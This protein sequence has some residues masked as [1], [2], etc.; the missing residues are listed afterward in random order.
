M[1]SAQ[2]LV[3]ET[4]SEDS[5]HEY[6]RRGSGLQ[7]SPKRQAKFGYDNSMVVNDDDKWR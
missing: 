3:I 2:S 1:L 7:E 5:S 4:Q 6:N